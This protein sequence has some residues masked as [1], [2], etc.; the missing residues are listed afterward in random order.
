MSWQEYITSLMTP[1]VKDAC[2]CGSNPP[3]I[4]ASEPGGFL[5]KMTTEEIAALASPDRTCFRINGLTLGSVKCSL[6]RDDFEESHTM[7]LRTKC[8]NGPTF[9]VVIAKE[10]VVRRG[11]C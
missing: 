11:R 1:E 8:A 3:S 9:N 4:W 7:D 6:L 10:I 2:I 5:S